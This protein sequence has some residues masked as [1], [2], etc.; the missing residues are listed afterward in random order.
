MASYSTIKGLMASRGCW[1][2][3]GNLFT[4]LIVDLLASRKIVVSEDNLF[5]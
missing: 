1:Y 4:C 3:R 5:M 2:L